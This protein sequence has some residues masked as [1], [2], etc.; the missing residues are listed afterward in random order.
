MVE[1]EESR[2]PLETRVP[3]DRRFLVVPGS[4]PVL[5]DAFTVEP[6]EV[7]REATMVRSSVTAKAEPPNDALLGGNAMPSPPL[8]LSEELPDGSVTEPLRTL[9][10][11]FD[12]GSLAPLLALP[13]PVG[14][15]LRGI[16][17][18]DSGSS[19]HDRIMTGGPE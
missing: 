16:V 17:G 7:D 12:A 8:R 3:A 4:R 2:P 18:V 13:R 10:R 5:S 15:L 19:G 11:G 14:S 1:P 6:V 9:G